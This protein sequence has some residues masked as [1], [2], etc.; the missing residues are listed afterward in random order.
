DSNIDAAIGVAWSKVRSAALNYFTAES[1]DALTADT[2]PDEALSHVAWDALDELSSGNDP[3][4]MISAKA[5]KA[6]QWRSWLAGGTVHCFDGVLERVDDGSFVSSRAPKRLSFDK[7]DYRS[8]F[9][10]RD[11]RI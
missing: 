3:I 5:A 1:F 9:K 6:D 7:D 11:R 4:E 10:R 2:I 8:Q